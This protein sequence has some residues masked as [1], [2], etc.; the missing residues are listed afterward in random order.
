MLINDPAMSDIARAAVLDVAGEEGLQQAEAGMGGEDFGRYLQK[1]PGAFVTIGSGDP[2][3]PQEE[4]PPGH[5]PR[6]TVDQRTLAYG[7]AWYVAL[8][9]RYF[10]SRSQ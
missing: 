4:R 7:V 6:S 1:V 3:V 10:A 9:R 2:A 5:N 8:T